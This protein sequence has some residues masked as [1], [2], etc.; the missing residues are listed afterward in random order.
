ML[1]LKVAE[2]YDITVGLNRVEY[3]VG[4]AVCLYQSVLFKVLIYEQSVKGGG[5]KSR[6]EHIDNYQQIHLPVSKVVPHIPSNRHSTL[7]Y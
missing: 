6:Q 1:T 4:S 7:F 2:A 5:I 3:A